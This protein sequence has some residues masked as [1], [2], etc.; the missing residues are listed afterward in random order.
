M[1]RERK[2]KRERERERE[3]DQ[4]DRPTDRQTV[5]HTETETEK[6]RFRIKNDGFIFMWI[7]TTTSE[8]KICALCLGSKM[9]LPGPLRRI[10]RVTVLL[11][12]EFLGVFFCT[13]HCHRT[14]VTCLPTCWTFQSGQDSPVNFLYICFCFQN[15]NNPG[16]SMWSD[17]IRTAE[18]VQKV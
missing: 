11:D 14:Y 18:F 7:G 5:R 13:D 4:R 6:E 9:S 2:K 10:S 12:L 8:Q 3:R 1:E 17:M 16:A 15:L